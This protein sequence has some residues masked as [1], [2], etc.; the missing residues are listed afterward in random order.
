MR[1]SS[2]I[3]VAIARPYDEVYDFLA[4][5]ANLARWA[6]TPGG[7]I[8]ALGDGAWLAEV[9]SG[10]AIMRFSPRNV[11]GVL[12]YDSQRRGSAE[13]ERVPARLYPNGEGAELVVLWMRR[14][15]DTEERFDSDVTWVT[16]DLERLKSL[17]EAT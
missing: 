13:R 2:V 4:D 6:T 1:A 3:K 15:G 10:Q 7:D 8:R 11:F 5:P 16:S 12:D 9:P 17:L 14:P